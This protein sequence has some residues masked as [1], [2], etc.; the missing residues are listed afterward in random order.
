MKQKVILILLFF[1]L[2]GGIFFYSLHQEPEKTVE[3]PIADSTY[4]KIGL[5]PTS[6]CLP[7]LVAE[8]YGIAD[9]CGLKL[10]T[11]LYDASMDADTAFMNGVVDCVMID[12]VKLSVMESRG[13]KVSAVFGGDVHLSVIV[14]RQSR[15]SDVKN[16]KD[17]IVSITRN[18]VVDMYADRILSDARLASTDI[19]KP[20]INSLPI[21][22]GMLLQNEYDGAILPEPWASMSVKHG[23]R[24][25]T[26]MLSVESMDKMYAV[27]FRDSVINRRRPDIYRLLNAYN[28]SVDYINKNRRTH[29]KELLGLLN[30]T[31]IYPD[32]VLGISPFPH[33]M[34]VSEGSLSTCRSWSRSRNLLGKHSKQDIINK[35][36]IKE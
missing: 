27:V 17:K 22:Y 3:R 5:I 8:H 30:I 31:T 4:L 11:Y 21:R 28:Q 35:E 32:S 24:R 29:I 12:L 9:S 26:S 7:F 15:I 33:T 20:Q 25:L 23:C 14:S 1:L 34:P 13:E 10:R 36:F 2:A 16:L 18:S 6:E 19:N